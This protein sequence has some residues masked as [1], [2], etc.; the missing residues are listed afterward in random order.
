MPLGLTVEIKKDGPD[1]SGPRRPFRADILASVPT[2]PLM[3]GGV[4]MVQGKAILIRPIADV[5]QA[6]APRGTRAYIHRRRAKP[7]WRCIELNARPNQRRGL[8]IF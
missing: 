8:R 4:N 7:E 2:A 6:E 1:V 5:Q 3:H